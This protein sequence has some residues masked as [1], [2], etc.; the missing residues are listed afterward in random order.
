MK[1]KLRNWINFIVITLLLTTAGFILYSVT[2]YQ[3]EY[4]EYSSYNATPSGIKALYLLAREMG[5]QVRRNHYPAKFV[6]DTPVMVIYRPDDM[7]FNEPDEQQYLSAWLD[8]GNTMVLMPDPE[9][10]QE[11]WIFNTI[12]EQKKQHEVKNIGTITI[13][14]YTLDK[15]RICVMDRADTFLNGQL[16]DSDAAVAFIQALEDAG[17]TRVVFN[18]YYQFLQKPAP[19]LWDL[20]GTLGQLIA[21]QLLLAFVLTVIRGWKPFGRVRNERELLKRPENEVQ[22]ALSGLYL[23]MKAYPLALSNYYGYFMQKY[24]RILST[25]G[26][27]SEKANRILSQCS[28]YIEENQKSKKEMLLLVRQLEKLEADLSGTKGLAYGHDRALWKKRKGSSR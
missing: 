24:N 1:K 28:R 10:I 22:R 19:D 21:I 16:K 5:F 9:T 25:P 3:K 7:L 23:R 2:V 18:E 4:P 11:L 26:P 17:N 13:T 12:S 6:Q 27:V 14:W 20:M 8:L 15:G